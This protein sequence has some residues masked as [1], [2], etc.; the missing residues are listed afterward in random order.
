MQKIST[1]N[2]VDEPMTTFLNCLNCG[3]EILNIYIYSLIY[4]Y[5]NGDNNTILNHYF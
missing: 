5:I 1:T 3:S 4:I 2:G